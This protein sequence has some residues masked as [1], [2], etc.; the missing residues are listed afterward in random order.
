ML[1]RKG[2]ATSL[3]DDYPVLTIRARAINDAG[4]PA[5]KKVLEIASRH[6]IVNFGDL[7]QGSRFNVDLQAI[8]TS[9]NQNTP[10]IHMV[11]T[12]RGDL[13]GFM[14][15]LKAADLGI[16]VVASGLFEEIFRCCAQAGLK[17]HTVSYS[18]GAFGSTDRLPEPEVLEV[19]TMCGHSLV[20]AGLVKKLAGQV[21]T[22]KLTP[23]KAAERLA[24]VC[25]C[26]IFNPSRAARLLALIAK[27]PQGAAGVKCRY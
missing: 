5:M 18:L 3:E 8:L 2:T 16:S 15:E 6:G 19:T 25:V 11:F 20:S 22:G 13:A 21:R 4:L 12:S 14:E 17:P 27:S 9:D 23:G 24:K 26:G 7:V 10:I 1:H